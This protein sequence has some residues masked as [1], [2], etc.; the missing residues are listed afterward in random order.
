MTN[1]IR[2]ATAD[3]KLIEYYHR[4][5]IEL[6][7]NEQD[8]VVDWE[9]HASAF[10]ADARQDRGFAG[11]LAFDEDVPV[12]AACCHIIDR[13]F[14]PIRAIDLAPTGYVWGVFIE[15]HARGKGLGTA[16]VD[17]CTRHLAGQECG[18]IL[19]HAGAF[20]R[21]LYERLGFCPTDELGIAVRRLP[22]LSR[23]LTVKLRGETNS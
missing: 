19:L 14:P 4:H 17:A 8:I 21:P 1:S 2:P 15:P 16:L 11:F 22:I 18:K 13:V 20:S 23:M 7:V 12:G 5:W 6:G 9:A 3:S 10:I